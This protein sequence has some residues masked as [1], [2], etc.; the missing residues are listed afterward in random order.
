MRRFILTNQPGY[1]LRDAIENPNFEKSVI[2]VL[3]NSGV[4]IDRIPVTPLTLH[5]YEPEPDPRYQKPQKIVTTSGEIEI[6]TFIPDDMVATGENP[7]VQIIY[8]FVRRRDGASL[9]D[10]TR[11]VTQ[12]RRIL[13]NNDYGIRRVESIVTEMNKGAVLG[14]LLVKKGN[15]YMPGVPLR[16]GREL[17]RLY[18]GYDPFE[19]QIMR[20][21][22][23]RGTASREEI[24]SF[25]M[26]GLKWARNSKLVEFYI[27]KLLK[28]GNIKR[29]SKNWFGY[30]KSL[31]PF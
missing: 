20:Y 25:I 1:D 27:K 16:T 11:H 10:I 22:E 15:I 13:P 17:I 26:D 5:M 18:S 3:D 8:R 21:I 9:E 2:V 6:P 7:F 19:Y 30:V 29:I 31:E 23:N 24:H 4:E 14:G 12:E 28:Q